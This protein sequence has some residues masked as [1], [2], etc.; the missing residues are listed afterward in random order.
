MTYRTAQKDAGIRAM[1]R[2][3]RLMPTALRRVYAPGY[4]P[5]LSGRRFSETRDLL[6]WAAACRSIE[7]IEN[8]LTRGVRCRIGGIYI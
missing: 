5:F 3:F 6:S 1:R 8:L 4:V 2:L 7:G